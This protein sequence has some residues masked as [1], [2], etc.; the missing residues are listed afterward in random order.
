MQTYG[1]DGRHRTSDLAAML[2]ILTAARRWI[3]NAWPWSRWRILFVEDAPDL[4]V[5]GSLYIVGGRK[6]PFPAVMDCPC[7][8]GSPIWLDLVP[9][10]HR[11]AEECVWLLGDDQV[12]TRA[13]GNLKRN[14]T[15]ISLF[16]LLRTGETAAHIVFLRRDVRVVA[17]EAKIVGRE[18]ELCQLF[19]HDDGLRARLGG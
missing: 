15:A 6:H 1:A 2:T 17:G 7:G 13:P 14:G 3:W 9:G 19:L 8:C 11:R 16:P 5:V 18:G 4:P 12:L 10:K